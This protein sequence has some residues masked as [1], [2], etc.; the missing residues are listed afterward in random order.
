VI[1]VVCVGVENAVD[2]DVSL[3]GSELAVVASGEGYHVFTPRPFKVRKPSLGILRRE[4]GG[5]TWTDREGAV[6]RARGGRAPRQLRHI[7]VEQLDP[8]IQRLVKGLF[9]AADDFLHV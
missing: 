1:M 6:V 9:L 5:P 8:S 3:G 2:H 4:S 7:F